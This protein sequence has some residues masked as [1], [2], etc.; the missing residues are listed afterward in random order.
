MYCF[1]LRWVVSVLEK[2][3]PARKFDLDRSFFVRRSSF[4]LAPGKELVNILTGRQQLFRSSA[5]THVENIVN[6]GRSNSVTGNLVAFLFTYFKVGLIGIGLLISLCASS[7]LSLFMIIKCV[8]K[9]Y[10]VLIKLTYLSCASSWKFSIMLMIL[11]ESYFL[12]KADPGLVIV[13]LTLA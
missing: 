10:E 3:G 1:S 13:R 12:A 7:G 8:R 11:V 5:A 9:R 2:L 6:I 4:L